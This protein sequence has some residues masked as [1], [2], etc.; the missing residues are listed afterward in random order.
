M[1]MT[2]TLL[3]EVLDADDVCLASLSLPPETWRQEEGLFVNQCEVFVPVQHTGMAARQR[4]SFCHDDIF[5][6]GVESPFMEGRKPPGK[7]MPSDIVKYVIG[8]L[9]LK[10]PPDSEF[11]RLLTRK[12]D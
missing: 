12:A 2:V 5:N 10:V 9:R 4:L 1:T 6:D 7:L 8:S 3:L 11:M